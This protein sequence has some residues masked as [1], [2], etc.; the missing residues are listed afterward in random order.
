MSHTMIGSRHVCPVCFDM[1]INE[2]CPKHATEHRSILI[3]APLEPLPPRRNPEKRR[4]IK[5]QGYRQHFELELNTPLDQPVRVCATCQGKADR[6]CRACNQWYCT[7]HAYKPGACKCKECKQ[8]IAQNARPRHSLYI[9]LCS[10]CA[11]SRY[12][13]ENPPKGY[14]FQHKAWNHFIATVKED[15]LHQMHG[16]TFTCPD[17]DFNQVLW[18][19]INLLES[20]DDELHEK[21]PI[22]DLSPDDF[23]PMPKDLTGREVIDFQELYKL[24][25]RVIGPHA[26]VV[27]RQKVLTAQYIAERLQCTVAQ[28]K[29]L[30]EAFI[31][32][33][34]T[35]AIVWQTLSEIK[36]RDITQS[37]E[38]YTML[39]RELDAIGPSADDAMEHV[40]TEG[41]EHNTIDR[42]SHDRTPEV[43]LCVI[44][45]A[46]SAAD[47]AHSLGCSLA[48][49]G[50]IRDDL[51]NQDYED[52]FEK[53]HVYE[54]R[55]SD[56]DQDEPEDILDDIDGE[57]KDL[58]TLGYVDNAEDAS[59][60]YTPANETDR[61][62]PGFIAIQYHTMDEIETIAPWIDRQP[63]Q[64]QR[65][66]YAIQECTK[67]ATLKQISQQLYQLKDKLTY[68]QKTG[69]WEPLNARK[70]A[71]LADI[72]RR[73]PKVHKGV[74]RLISADPKE[75]PTIKFK[76]V[77]LQHNHPN[78]YSKEGWTVLWERFKAS[79]QAR[80]SAPRPTLRLD[81]RPSIVRQSI[82]CLKYEREPCAH[83]GHTWNSWDTCSVLVMPVAADT[84]DALVSID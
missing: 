42:A 23:E 8:F 81:C 14:I 26:A 82:H 58:D 66:Y 37:I 36:S 25:D 43:E 73:N 9:K 68:Q 61:D 18:D 84:A 17:A 69:L 53:C 10:A 75:L 46:P 22:F 30:A 20:R 29:A 77:N 19:S 62:F 76:I 56:F 59:L 40:N 1:N 2:V 67:I 47:I 71:L 39:V 78:F 41:T 16:S 27:D 32:L 60:Q 7:K 48:Q 3:P 21:D 15:K 70:A 35:K 74:A 5:A 31:A 55:L 12:N 28:G 65:L 57:D 52:S 49:A 24:G 80:P 34:F 11:Q 4:D 72:Q 54:R 83:A 79:A 13:T 51:I 63:K 45:G 38:Y 44:E 33:D 50:D 64:V 6:I